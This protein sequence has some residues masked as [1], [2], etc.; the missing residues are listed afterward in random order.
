MALK[1][2]AE[3]LQG[4]RYKLQMMG[5]PIEGPT[6]MRVEN[7]SVVNKTTSPDSVLQ[8]KSNSIAYHFVCQSVAGG[9]LKI[10]YENTL[11]SLADMLMK[12]QSGEERKRLAAMVIF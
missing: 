11:T 12:T 10:G 4:L 7:M 3:I 6:H 5:I 2:V 8:K 1:T 9:C